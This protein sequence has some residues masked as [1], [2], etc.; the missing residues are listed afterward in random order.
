V[1]LPFLGQISI[2]TRRKIEWLFRKYYPQIK[3]NLIFT[4]NNRIESFFKF[5]DKLPNNLCSSVIYKYTCDACED[6]Y[7]GKTIRNLSIRIDEHRG[8]SFRTKS[9]L[10]NPMNSNIRNHSFNCDCPIRNNNFQILDYSHERDLCALESL[11]IWHLK[12]KI[13]SAGAS[14]NLFIVK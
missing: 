9:V 13:N 14:E 3:L 8:L 6:I 4:N 5:K 10:F 7:I 12:P 1:N 11:Y 2:P